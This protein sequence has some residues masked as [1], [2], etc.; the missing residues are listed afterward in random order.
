M[1]NAFPLNDTFNL[2]RVNESVTPPWWKIWVRHPVT[3]M[4]QECKNQSPGLQETET[5]GLGP[6]CP[7]SSGPKAWFPFKLGSHRVGPLCSH[8][9][10]QQEWGLWEGA[11]L[12]TETPGEVHKEMGRGAAC[13]PLHQDG[14]EVYSPQHP[15]VPPSL[16][17]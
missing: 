17:L 3:G 14:Q 2:W 1:G 6:H 7:H 15:R 10:K 5:W 16:P 4:L 12:L 11:V 8:S 9:H 13:L